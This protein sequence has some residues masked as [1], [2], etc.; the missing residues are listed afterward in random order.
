MAEDAATS[1]DKRAKFKTATPT[2]PAASAAPTQEGGASTDLSPTLDGD[3]PLLNNDDYMDMEEAVGEVPKQRKCFPRIKKKQERMF[4]ILCGVGAIVFGTLILGIPSFV[5]LRAALNSGKNAKTGKWEG[6]PEK[7]DKH[8]LPKFYRHTKAEAFQFGCV[9]AAI[10]CIFVML[11]IILISF[12]ACCVK[13]L[14]EPPKISKEDDPNELSPTFMHFHH[15]TC[16]MEMRSREFK[17][18]KRESHTSKASSKAKTDVSKNQ[19]E[20]SST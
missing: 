4:H 10:S 16:D 6:F 12:N 18:E 7:I 19:D 20:S 17:R 13:N 15:G 11:G 2:T 14:P 5:V 9:I 3:D 8:N 1:A